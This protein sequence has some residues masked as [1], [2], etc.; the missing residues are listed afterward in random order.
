MKYLS[1]RYGVYRLGEGR[2]LLSTM[3]A[4]IRHQRIPAP[5]KKR[6]TMAVIKKTCGRY[7]PL[8]LVVAVFSASQGHLA[9]T[10]FSTLL[11]AYSLI[12]YKSEARAGKT[13]K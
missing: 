10:I 4:G 6:M 1:K 12:Q 13:G 2:Y 8:F 11:L 9:L 3:T 5:R 7:R